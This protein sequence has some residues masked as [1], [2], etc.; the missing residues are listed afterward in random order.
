ML[1]SCNQSRQESC[2]DQHWLLPSL[3]VVCLTLLLCDPRVRYPEAVVK[4][5]IQGSW[6]CQE[7]AP[8]WVRSRLLSLLT[9]LFLLPHDLSLI[10]I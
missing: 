5:P 2:R 6:L 8:L 4:P 3:G 10:H 1:L 7:W 9:T